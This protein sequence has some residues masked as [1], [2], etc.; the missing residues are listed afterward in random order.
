MTTETPLCYKEIDHAFPIAPQVYSYLRARIVDNRLP[1]GAKISE[2]SVADSLNISRTPLRAALQKL[3]TE[4]LVNTRP[5]VGTAVA[6]LD[7]AQLHGAVFIRAALETAV[8]R[9]L[10]EMKADLRTLDP[11]MEIQKRAAERDDYAGFFVQDEAFHAELAR[12]AGV[13]DAWRLALSTKGHVDRQRYMLMASIAK[14][15]LRAYEEHIKINKEIRSGDADAAART[16]HDHVNSV[17]E[18]DAHGLTKDTPDRSR[19]GDGLRNQP[20]G[21]TL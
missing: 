4:G 18:L 2:A 14:R 16:M 13:P 9:K 6:G 12:I 21:G 10:A 20:T 17:L 11:I 15:S 1:P 19:A 7:V 8:V 3:A 5:N